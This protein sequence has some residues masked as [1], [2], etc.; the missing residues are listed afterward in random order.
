MSS[1]AGCAGARSAQGLAVGKG[2]VF[3]ASH[4]ESLIRAKSLLTAS[5]HLPPRQRVCST[6]R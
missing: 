2:N 3:V 1:H 5:R 4:V 6:A